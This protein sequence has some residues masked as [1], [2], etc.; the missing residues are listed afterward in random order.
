SAPDTGLHIWTHEEAMSGNLAR[1]LVDGLALP[2]WHYQYAHHTHGT[3]VYGLLLAPIYALGGSSI[4]WVKALGLVFAA[5]GTALWIALVRRAFGPRA[6]VAFAAWWLFAPPALVQMQHLAWANHMESIAWIGAMLLVFAGADDM[7]PSPKRFAWLGAL[8]GFASFFCL[9]SLLVAAPI[10]LLTVW[11]WRRASVRLLAAALPAFVATYSP[12]WF[13]AHAMYR[14]LNLEAKHPD[15]VARARAFAEVVPEA[16]AYAWPVVTGVAVVV[17]AVALAF[18]VREFARPARRY[19]DRSGL[20][21][22]RALVLHIAA[23]FAANVLSTFAVE[24]Y[25]LDVYRY[26]YVTPLFA[27]AMALV[28]WAFASRPR[29]AACVF[30]PLLVAGAFDARVPQT[31]ASVA[32]RARKGIPGAWMWELRGDNMRPIVEQN[33][34][35]AWGNALEIGGDREGTWREI[36][37]QIER[38]PS[39]W[40]ALACETLALDRG[41]QAPEFVRASCGPTADASWRRGLGRRQLRGV[42]NGMFEDPNPE[43]VGR[44][45][46]SACSSGDADFARGFAYEFL[47]QYEVRTHARFRIEDVA[48]TREAIASLLANTGDETC[49]GAAIANGMG[50]FIAELEL[51][52]APFTAVARF[53]PLAPTPERAAEFENG[54]ASGAALAFVAKWRCAPGDLAALRVPGLGD[55]LAAMGIR[56]VPRDGHMCLE[57]AGPGWTPAGRAPTMP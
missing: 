42:F 24:P 39:E 23:F 2:A 20:W 49:A 29:I 51:D 57:R 17:V 46:E 55:R 13:Y 25:A 44:S 16:F 15:L 6:A 36:A 56:V 22:L 26:R 28:A 53:T 11:R 48:S 10:A 52:S 12:H 21:V 4:L 33:A 54:Y 30:V 27:T 45:F 38:L 9:Q 40:R 1:A 43:A 18:A 19:A 8:A 14:S 32:S 7:E 3:F 35:F 47:A 41:E 5:A 31:I 34:P 50:R 37:G